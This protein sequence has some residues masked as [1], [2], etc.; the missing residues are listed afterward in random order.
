MTLQLLHSEFSY[1]YLYFY[2]YFVFYR[3]IIIK[4]EEILPFIYSLAFRN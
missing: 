3:C 2:I 1:F 4:Y